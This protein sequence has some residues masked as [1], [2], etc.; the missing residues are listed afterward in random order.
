[1]RPKKCKEGAPEWV[2]TYGDM[3]SLLLTFF[4]MLYS[5]STLQKTKVQT[6]VESFSNQFGYAMTQ[7]PVPGQQTPQNSNKSQIRST[8]R[9]R[10]NDTLRGGNPVL[11]PQGDYAKVRSVRPNK[12]N[13]EGGIVYFQVGSDELTDRGRLDIKT[14][15]DQLRGSPYK[16]MIKGHTSNTE[17]GI[18]ANN[19]YYL[20]FSR[21]MKVREELIRQGVKGGLLQVISVGPDEPTPES[22]STSGL[23]PQQANAFVEV[24]RLLDP[25]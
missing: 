19:L 17:P 2:L 23:T 24:L 13:V 7:V 16:V 15:A 6:I 3:M 4:I 14:I 25:N 12:E 5:M 9:A 21:A 8:G 11:A 22:L 20:G 10:R 18:Y 1:M